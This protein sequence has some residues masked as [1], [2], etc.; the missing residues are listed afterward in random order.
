MIVLIAIAKLDV[1]ELAVSVTTDWTPPTSLASRLWISPVRVSGEE[2]QR[3][4]LEVGV[5]R[6]AEVL[7]HALADQ[8]VQ[9]RLT[10]ADQARDDRQRDHQQHED[11]QQE[12]VPLRDRDVD[13]E[14]QEDRVDQPEEARDEDR[15]EDDRD[16]GRYGLKKTRMRRIV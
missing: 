11:V 9:V 10:D 12:Q 1:T 15:D 7:H 5:E 16:L 2:P 14:L 13:E 8:V 6:G 3:H 4:A